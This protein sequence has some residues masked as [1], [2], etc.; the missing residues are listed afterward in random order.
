M[1]LKFVSLEY[2]RIHYFILFFSRQ[3][4]KI[5]RSVRLW[6]LLANEKLNDNKKIEAIPKIWKMVNASNIFRCTPMMRAIVRNFI[7]IREPDYEL[8]KTSRRA[9]SFIEIDEWKETQTRPS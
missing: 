2:N 4:Q 8:L 5:T 7:V 6:Q 9:S 3:S 1:I